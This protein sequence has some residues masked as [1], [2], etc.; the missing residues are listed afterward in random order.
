[1]NLL[2]SI[3]VYYKPL[4]LWSFAIN[5]IILIM[6]QSYALTLC[7]KLFLVILFWLLLKDFGVRRKIGFYKMVGVSN[8][9]LL[10]IIYII[11]CLVMLTFL[12]LI[13][14]FVY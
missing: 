14:G 1:M 4:F 3:F 11:D 8:F 5:L 9:K 2:K 13:K 7:A 10:G 6:S 12:L